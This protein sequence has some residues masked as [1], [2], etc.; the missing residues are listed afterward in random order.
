MAAN[1]YQAQLKAERKRQEEAEE[2]E[3]RQKMLQKFAEDDRLDQMNEQRRRMRE[4][5]HKR[6]ADM[7]WKQK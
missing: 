4:L 2:I 3:F 1:E 5:E 6:N 7:L